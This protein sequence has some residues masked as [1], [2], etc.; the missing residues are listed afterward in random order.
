M[1]AKNEGQAEVDL[2]P[3]MQQILREI[4][5]ED[6]P[7]RLLELARRLQDAMK[8]RELAVDQEGG[9]GHRK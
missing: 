3:D 1:N 5:K 7:Q 9:V 4:E 8:A 2:T 6:V